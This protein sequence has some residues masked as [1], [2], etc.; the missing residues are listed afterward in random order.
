MPV[1]G[2]AWMSG[3]R[4]DVRTAPA[5]CYRLCRT[6]IQDCTCALLSFV[7]YKDSIEGRSVVGGAWMSGLRL[8]VVIV[9]AAVVLVVLRWYKYITV[10]YLLLTLI[11]RSPPAL[12]LRSYNIV[13]LCV[14]IVG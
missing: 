8:R 2:S 11:G 9:W 4:L 7:P 14:L 3:L 5:R 10:P 12:H 13:H 6:R 1:V